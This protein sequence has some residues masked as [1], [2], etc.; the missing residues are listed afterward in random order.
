VGEDRYYAQ[1]MQTAR[2]V[3]AVD[4][5]ERGQLDRRWRDLFGEPNSRRGDPEH[6]W[7]TRGAL[8]LYQAER[9]NE[10][11][12]LPMDWIYTAVRC[13]GG[14]LPRFLG[15]ERVCV[16]PADLTWAMVFLEDDLEGGPYFQRGESGGSA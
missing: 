3:E 7:T 4:R 6:R 16:V 8:E 12:V 5:K 15:N 14:L 9:P 2:E 11:V 10:F 13:R 1:M